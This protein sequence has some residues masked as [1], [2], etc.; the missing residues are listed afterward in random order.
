MVKEYIYE[1][2]SY[3]KLKDVANYLK[4]SKGSADKMIQNAKH[5]LI[6][7]NYISEFNCN[8]N[9][10]SQR[11][12]FLISNMLYMLLCK[13]SQMCYQT[14][15]KLRAYKELLDYASGIQHLVG[16]DNRKIY[17]YE[18]SF[19]DE[20][21]E[22]GSFQDI[23]LVDR[24]RT[25]DFGRIDLY[26]IDFNNFKCCIELKKYAKSNYLFSQLL[27]YKNSMKFD[28]VIYIGYGRDNSLF[29]WCND[30]CVEYYSYYRKLVINANE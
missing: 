18:N 4:L 24:E 14:E 5:D 30:N 12:T 16:T 29:K 15:V 8:T 17:S 27:R 25:Y 2:T 26:G 3:I 10:G 23:K 20:L 21:F 1:G 19:R 9:S 11:C 28:R 22:I 7:Q 6:L 13:M